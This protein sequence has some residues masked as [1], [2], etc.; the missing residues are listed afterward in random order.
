MQAEKAKC[1]DHN[2]RRKQD[3]RQLPRATHENKGIDVVTGADGLL[4]CIVVGVSCK[5]LAK[6]TVNSTSLRTV[7]EQHLC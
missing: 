1:G 6:N 2:Y 5:T 4:G 7:N 3:F